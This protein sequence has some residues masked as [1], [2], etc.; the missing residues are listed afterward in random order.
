MEGVTFSLEDSLKMI[1]DHPD[2][3]L[4]IDI[5][6]AEIRN[7]EREVQMF[8]ALTFDECEYL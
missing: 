3:N 8:I 2:V 7:P 1:K 6:W 4:L 5:K